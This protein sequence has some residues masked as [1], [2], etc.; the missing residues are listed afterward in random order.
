MQEGG[1]EADGGAVHEHEF[2]RN[3]DRALFLQRLTHPEGF[4]PPVLA[5]RHAVGD[6]AHPVIEEGTIDE[7]RPDV[8]H[9]HE[10]VVQTLEPPSAIGLDLSLAIIVGEA[11]EQAHHAGHEARRE[12]AHAAEI[13]Q[14]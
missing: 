13:E 9:V 2:A 5:G 6:R 3:D 7:P 14:V 1:A 11:T 12:D 10:I 4:G 8:Q